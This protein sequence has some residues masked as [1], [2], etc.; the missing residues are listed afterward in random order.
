MCPSSIGRASCNRT[1][2]RGE[3][4][5]DENER[6]S[7][8]NRTC[9][10]CRGS[11]V[12]IALR[13]TNGIVELVFPAQVTISDAPENILDAYLDHEY[14]SAVDAMD[15]PE[16]ALEEVRAALSKIPGNLLDDVRAE[17][18]ARD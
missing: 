15:E 4:E 12:R 7:A 8:E 2:R 5:A 1:C 11:P 9:F 3:T 10:G 17:C 16:P 6:L 14:M 13:A 18:D